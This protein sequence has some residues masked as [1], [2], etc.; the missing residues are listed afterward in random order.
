[1]SDNDD[2]KAL[3]AEFQAKDEAYER[4][5]KRINIALGDMRSDF[6]SGLRDVFN[7]LDSNANSNRI[8]LPIVLSV[9]GTILSVAVVAGVIHTM[10]LSPLHTEDRALE[11]RLSKIENV[12]QNEVDSGH[13]PHALSLRMDYIEKLSDGRP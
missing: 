4:E 5:F 11:Y 12:L 10:S 7:K 9:V 2:I 8:T 13:N 6:Q 1:M 3:R